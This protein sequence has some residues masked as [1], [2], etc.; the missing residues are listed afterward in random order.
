MLFR[1]KINYIDAGEKRKNFTADHEEIRKARKEVEEISL[2]SI[3]P[4][5]EYGNR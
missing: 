2:H 3:Y 5:S 1:I 4:I